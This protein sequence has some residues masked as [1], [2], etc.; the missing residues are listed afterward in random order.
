VI[1]EAAILF[2]SGFRN[3]YDYTIHVSCP[4][5]IAIE[6]V[7]KRDATNRAAV[8]DRMKFQMNNEEKSQLAD[9]VIRNDGSELV[10]P[11]VLAI[12]RILCT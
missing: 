10:I 3:E 5:E 4:P 2:E 9:F 11:Q 7:I 1:Q 8:L 12:H 6:R